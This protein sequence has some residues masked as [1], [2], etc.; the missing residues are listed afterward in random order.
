MKCPKCG[1][2]IEIDAKVDLYICAQCQYKFRVESETEITEVQEI[3][4]DSKVLVETKEE[5]V[6]YV[7]VLPRK[8]LADDPD[9]VD[10]SLSGKSSNRVLL[11]DGT[12]GV[13]SVGRNVVKIQHRGQT[14][15]LIKFSDEERRRWRFWTNSISIGI[16]ILFIAIFFWLLYRANG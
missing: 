13:T 9:F 1:A 4:T 14:I 5:T 11:P 2:V 3:N 16:G 12:G 7:S 8:F 6:A 10:S 15:E